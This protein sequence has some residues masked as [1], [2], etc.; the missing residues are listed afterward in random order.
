MTNNARME[1]NT[2]RRK[3]NLYNCEVIISAPELFKYRKQTDKFLLTVGGC[4]DFEPDGSW[5]QTKKLEKF[6]EERLELLS[7]QRVERY[8]NLV[9]GDWDPEKKLVQLHKELGKFWVYMGFV[10]KSRKW[11]YP[12]EALF[13]METNTM[14]VMYKGLP[15]SIQ[16]A[17]QCFFSTEVTLEQYQVYTHLR[18][19]GYVLVRHQG[20]LNVTE[21]E[22][23]IK[24]DQHLKS[25]KRKD[26]KRKSRKENE[27]NEI[28]KMKQSNSAQELKPSEG[29]SEETCDMEIVEET[30]IDE[31]MEQT[32]FIKS[33]QETSPV[34]GGLN[35]IAGDHHDDMEINN[36]CTAQT[37]QIKN[38]QEIKTNKEAQYTKLTSDRVSHDN[39]TR[40]SEAGGDSPVIYFSYKMKSRQKCLD[41]D[42]SVS[43]SQPFQSSMKNI[44]TNQPPDWSFS[45]I[46]FPDIGKDKVLHFTKYNKNPQLFPQG[47]QLPDSCI[48]DSEKYNL[49]LTSNKHKKD[50]ENFNLEYSIDPSQWKK[51]PVNAKNWKEYKEKSN[52]LENREEATPVSH[53]WKGEVTPLVKPCYS[54]LDSVIEKLQVVKNSSFMSQI[55]R[56]SSLKDLQHKVIYDVY[57]PDS[58]FK[59][60]SPGLP[61]HRLCVLRHC[62]PLPDLQTITNLH[63]YYTDGI[64]LQWAVVD[65]GDIAFYGFTDIQI[66]DML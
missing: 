39:N 21:Y 15:L 26:K 51:K 16:Q 27:S 61:H 44:S 3:S 20:R 62:E 37:K 28:K 56:S 6:Y 30:S 9:T 14:E 12:E 24:L 36:D 10:D 49:N 40:L 23:K 32:S 65:H 60:S 2:E 53:L 31:S 64:P 1:Q 41:S 66:P 42:L 22:K 50:E 46:I 4:K 63:H 13:L 7:E 34:D 48:F 8:G 11:L 5:L 58:K 38:E 45:E 47:V 29:A 18:R 54:S 59:K 52:L 35:R 55:F 19:L 57:L 17:Y 43:F 33:V 25:D